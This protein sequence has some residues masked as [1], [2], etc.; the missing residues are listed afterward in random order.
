MQ[1]DSGCFSLGALSNTLPSCVMQIYSKIV[2]A[3]S[4]Q[5]S[6][7]CEAGNQSFIC[8]SSLLFPVVA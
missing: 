7:L 6:P 1:E 3:M 2:R 8:V 4:F 5:Y